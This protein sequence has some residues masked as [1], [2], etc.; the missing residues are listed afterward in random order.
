[1]H[2]FLDGWTGILQSS[3]PGTVK[4]KCSWKT[5]SVGS[6]TGGAG[7]YRTGC[8]SLCQS[9]P[10]PAPPVR[11]FH[12]VLLQK[13]SL[14]IPSPLHRVYPPPPPPPPR[15]RAVTALSGLGDVCGWKPRWGDEGSLDR[16]RDGRRQSTATWP[17]TLTRGLP[18]LCLTF[19]N[20]DKPCHLPPDA[21]TPKAG[22]AR[23][24]I[25]NSSFPKESPRDL[26]Q[27][28]ALTQ[29]KCI[30]VRKPPQMAPWVTQPDERKA[31]RRADKGKGRRCWRLIP[32]LLLVPSLP[33]RGKNPG[34]G[35]LDSGSS[36]SPHNSLHHPWPWLPACCFSWFAWAASSNHNEGQWKH[37]HQHKWS[38]WA[39]P[40]GPSLLGLRCSQYPNRCF[41]L[42]N[43][44]LEFRG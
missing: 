21:T 3:A 2:Y 18:A 15:S 22:K 19:T 20:G 8:H 9:K 37:R 24:A 27:G 7:C 33:M 26:R 35:T 5:P 14:Q 38:I 17:W 11:Y 12:P 29:A 41:L 44:K 32:A 34:W 30:R 43:H 10:V 4:A 36:M 23:R 1:M 13:T 39:L 31:E 6:R 28:T 16:L 25:N 40:W 42:T